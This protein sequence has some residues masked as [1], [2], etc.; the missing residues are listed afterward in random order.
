MAHLLSYTG[1]TVITAPVTGV[2][3]TITE[4]PLSKAG[5]P[6]PIFDDDSDDE[7]AYDDL[8]P[9]YQVCVADQGD[10]GKPQR[11]ESRRVM[12]S[13]KNKLDN[14]KST[15]TNQAES[16]SSK[17]TDKV[18]QDAKTNPME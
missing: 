4:A 8:P 18:P 5:Q 14:V 16:S 10:Q 7:D 13:I 17:S 9:P 12:H 1:E 15:L 11:R 2:E 6:P 3:S